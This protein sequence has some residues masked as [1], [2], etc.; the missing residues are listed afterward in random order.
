MP[1]DASSLGAAHFGVVRFRSSFDFAKTIEGLEEAITS[2]GLTIFARIDF[3]GDAER[4]GLSMRPEKML[5]F[6]NPKSGTLLMKMEPAIGLDLPLKVLVWEDEH[7]SAWIACNTPEYIVG[8]H[9]LS[10]E[11]ASQL[12]PAMTILQAFM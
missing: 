2:R 5:I 12:A 4:A 9:E 6:G 8:R 3:S 10:P 1:K 7:G 11:T